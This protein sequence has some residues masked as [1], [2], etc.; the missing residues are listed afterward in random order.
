[1][2]VNLKPLKIRVIGGNHHEIEQQ[3]NQ[4]LDEYTAVT[5]NFCPILDQ[6]RVTVVLLHN[7]VVR[8]QMIA[9]PALG[10]P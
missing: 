4:L 3:L 2:D 9:Q 10:R 1:M 5:W 8:M 7:S 6:V